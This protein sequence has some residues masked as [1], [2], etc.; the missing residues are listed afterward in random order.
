MNDNLSKL[1]AGLNHILAMWS[2]P[3]RVIRTGS[4]L[5]DQRTGYRSKSEPLVD[6]RQKL[7]NFEF[8]QCSQRL[9]EAGHWTVDGSTVRTKTWFLHRFGGMGELSSGEILGNDSQREDTSSEKT[10][11]ELVSPKLCKN[12]KRCQITSWLGFSIDSKGA[13]VLYSYSCFAKI[14][15]IWYLEVGYQ[16]DKRN[17]SR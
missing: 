4:A 14:L 2:M 5:M 15:L 7:N 12:Q 16:R 1:C 17:S 3:A 9:S 8:C 13:L 11:D 6:I 10:A